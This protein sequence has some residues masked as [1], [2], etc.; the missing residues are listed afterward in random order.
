M[1]SF[2][3]SHTQDSYPPHLFLMLTTHIDGGKRTKSSNLQKSLQL[4]EDDET[5]QG[6]R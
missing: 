3:L 5:D 1:D 6:R 2:V 4:Y